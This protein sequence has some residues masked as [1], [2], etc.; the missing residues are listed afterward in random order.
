MA[1]GGTRGDLSALVGALS[2]ALDGRR[3]IWFGTRGEDGEALLRL[4]ELQASFAVTAP[5]RSGRL[6]ERSNLT[7]ESLSGERPDLDRHDID[8]DGS[9][10]ADEF[11]RRLIREASTR[12][13]VITYRPA[14]FVS[15]M[16]FSLIETMV[17]AGL[18][19]DRQLAFEHKPWVETSLSRLGVRTLGW[20]YVADEHR[21]RVRRLADTGALVLRANRASGG[22][23]VVRVDDA[24]GVDELWPADAEGFVGAA[25]YLDG[26]IPLNFSGCVYPNGAVRLHPLSFQIIGVPLCTER[27]FGYCGNDFAAAASLP[28]RVLRDLDRMGRTVGHW[29]HS[30]RYFGAFGVDAL[31]KDEQPHFTEVNPR[32]QGSS[33]LSAEIAAQL[34]LPDL[35]LEHLAANLGVE[36]ESRGLSLREWVA[37]APP[38][39]HVVVHNTAGTEVKRR[40]PLVPPAGGT[41]AQLLPAGVRALP[42]ATL[43]RVCMGGRATETGFDLFEEV[44]ETIERAVSCF[45]AEASDVTG[46]VDAAHA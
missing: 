15:A 26:A 20:R 34:E 4:P 37:Q 3:L 40:Q 31:L 8:L 38:V 42:G 16:S 23:G 28:D 21:P 5:I 14:H 32:F 44:Q 12:C 30:E 46:Q 11:R 17:L 18:F 45:A 43:F 9:A 36:P 6:D 41:I 10:A 33:A 29:L 27:P 2:R 39:A 25:E 24:T 13:A 7:L 19:K 22:V 1:V 35:F